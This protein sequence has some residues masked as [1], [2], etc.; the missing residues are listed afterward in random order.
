MRTKKAFKELTIQDDFMFYKIMQNRGLCVKI[1]QT[2]LR[3]KIGKITELTPQNIV[4]N[5]YGSK[6]VRFDV[7]VKDDKQRL[8]NIE[9][10]MMN[11]YY[12]VFRLRYYQGSIDVSSLESGQGYDE[13]PDVIIIFLCSKDPLGYNLPVYTLKNYC[14]QTKSIVDNGATH[15]I[16]NYSLYELIEDEELRA[17]CRYCKTKEISSKLTEE[18]DNMINEIK[19]NEFARQEYSFLFNR[20][21]DD[22]QRAIKQSEKKGIEKGREES[23]IYL[24]KSFR[25]AGF[26]LDRISQ[27]TGLSI[28]EIKKL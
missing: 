2:L 8:Y 5:T 28:D 22:I 16:V 21:P 26:P 14:V 3:N 1:I 12:I 25:D 4:K 19:Q 7:L 13:L 23:F 27:A 10:Q 15:I 9:M 20:Y 18:V 11:E 24:A 6:G 17:F